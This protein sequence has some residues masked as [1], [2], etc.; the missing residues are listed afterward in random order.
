MYV[1]VHKE[2]VLVGPRDWNRPM[3]E[4]ALQKL[5]LETLLP[6]RDPQ[7]LPIL[8]DEDTYITSAAIVIP[9]H[10]ERIETYHGPYW[11]FEN[12]D[13]AVG[14]YEIKYKTLGSIRELLTNEAAAERY[15]REVA[16]TKTTIQDLEVTLD[17]S[18][19]GRNVFIQKY[20]L[21]GENDTVNW[22]F[23]EGWLTLTK[24]ELGAAVSAGA[25]HIQGSFDWEKAKIEEIE[26]AETVEVL[27]AIV[28]VEPQEELSEQ[29]L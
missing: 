24:V 17:T 10:N 9:P 16:G 27:D 22:K 14:T 15:R 5:K 2:R 25:A 7:E 4:G 3:F 12:K 6:R 19:D 26:A 11:N 1:L 29:P 18:R 21:M 13:L 20:T 28:I 23:P 8:I